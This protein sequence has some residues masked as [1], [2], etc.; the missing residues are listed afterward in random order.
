MEKSWNCVFE[1]LLFSD[2]YTHGSRSRVDDI[3]MH[4]IAPGYAPIDQR[5]QRNKPPVGGV[6]IFPHVSS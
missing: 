1:F 2:H 5:N 3:P 4:D 6:A